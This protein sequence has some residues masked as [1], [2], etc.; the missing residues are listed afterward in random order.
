ERTLVVAVLD[1][2]RLRIRWSLDVIALADGKHEPSD[3]R[4]TGGHGRLLSGAAP[5]RQRLQCLQNTV[6]A[7]VHPDWRQIAPV[8]QSLLVDDEQCSLRGA[9][10]RAVRTV[11]LGRCTL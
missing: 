2:G 11:G 8:D 9:L 5:L 4:L 10:D 3:S 1:E 6:G 7:G